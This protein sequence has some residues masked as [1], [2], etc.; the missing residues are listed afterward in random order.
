MA[1][2]AEKILSNKVERDVVSG[3]IVEVPIDLALGQDF[4]FPPVIGEF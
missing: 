3:D 1:T 4:S 2:A